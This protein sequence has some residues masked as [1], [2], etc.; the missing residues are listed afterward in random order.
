LGWEPLSW[1]SFL[2]RKTP[3]PNL[4]RLFFLGGGQL[5][6]Q[7]KPFGSDVGVLLGHLV[8]FWFFGFLGDSR[9]LSELRGPK[10]QLCLGQH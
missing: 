6:T 9:G 3:E 10:E 1:L 7:V 8:A 4:F 5:S 2:A